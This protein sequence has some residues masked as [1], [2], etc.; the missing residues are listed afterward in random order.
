MVA[1]GELLVSVALKTVLGKLANLAFNATWNDIALQLNFIKDLKSIKDNLSFIQSFLE[2]A[3]RQ[4]SRL[5]SVRHTLKKLKAAAYDLEDMLL[6][7]ESWTTAHKGEGLAPSAKATKE[8]V[9]LQNKFNFIEHTS[10]NDEEVIRKRE[11]FSDA[12]EVPVG[13][14]EEKE[15]LISMLQ[16]DDSNFLIVFISGFAGVG[17]TTLAQMVFNDDRTRQFFE[18]QAWVYVSVKFDIM[19]IGQSII[20]QLDKSSSPAGITLQATRDRLKTIL[21][22]Q[23]FLIVVDDIWEEDPHELEKLRTLLR[24]AKAGSK[25]IATTRSVKVAKLMNGSLTIELGALPDN[26]CWELFR[27]KA[28]PY[29][30]VDVDKESTGRQIVKKCR[31]MPL[32]AISLGYLCRTTNEWKAILDSDIWAENG[33]DGRLLKDTKV[34]PSLKLSYQYMSYHLKLCFAYCAVSPK[35]WYVE[36]SSLIQQWISLG[37]VQL[38]GESFTAQLAGERY[39]EDLREMS[40]LQDVAGMSPTVRLSFFFTLLEIKVLF[41]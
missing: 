19:T 3:E 13:R 6:L 12:D 14:M 8:I 16:T 28:F 26:Y 4:S 34:L 21:E 29:G 10:N 24:G 41:T 25:I 39:F 2:D 38:H 37:F 36:K 11:T 33:D 31:G 18:I 40:F 5:E 22:G 30:K 20:S 1:V 35:G 7:F 9:D 27:A 32:A 23:Q 17:K 15:R